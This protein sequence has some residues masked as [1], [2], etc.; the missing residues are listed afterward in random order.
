MKFVIDIVNLVKTIINIVISYYNFCN[1]II[2]R[3]NLLFIYK[4]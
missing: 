1:C 4:F 3:E 2:G